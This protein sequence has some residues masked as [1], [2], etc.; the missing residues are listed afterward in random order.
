M[1]LQR[2]PEAA[3]K[4]QVVQFKGVFR[5]L[6]KTSFMWLEVRRPGGRAEGQADPE[7]HA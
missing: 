7:A 1:G 6:A 4:K 2:S 5:A 3:R